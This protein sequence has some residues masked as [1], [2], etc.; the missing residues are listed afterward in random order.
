MQNWDLCAILTTSPEKE[1]L[2]IQCCAYQ[3]FVT[4]NSTLEL[5]FHVLYARII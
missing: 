3:V 5:I 4:I 1:N 2:F